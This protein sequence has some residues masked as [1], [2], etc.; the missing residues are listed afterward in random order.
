MITGDYCSHFIAGGVRASGFFRPTSRR[1]DE[2]VAG[3][4]QL[5]RKSTARFRQRIVKHFRAPF[6]FRR[7]RGF[8]RENVNDAPCFRRTNDRSHVALLHIDM[9]K[10]RAPE[11]TFISIT[12]ALLDTV[13]DLVNDLRQNRELR[14]IVCQF[15]TQR[16]QAAVR[17]ADF[18]TIFNRT[19]TIRRGHSFIHRRLVMAEEKGG[20]QLEPPA[21]FAFENAI[22]DVNGV[23][24]MQHQNTFLENEVA[25]MI[26]PDRQP[27]FQAEFMQIIG[28]TEIKLAAGSFFR[29]E[30]DDIVIRETQ[31]FR[32]MA[33]H[34]HAPVRRRKGRN[35]QAVMTP[36]DSAR[37]RARSETAES[38]SHKPLAREEQFS[39]MG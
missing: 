14:A 1:D 16:R 22:D 5:G 7:Y 18:I 37:D 19:Q 15:Y 17:G 12:A 33:P 36:R 28:G 3:K 38:I 32:N 35:K 2:L 20:S 24:Q 26:G 10:S 31:E 11:V 30:G 6:F 39:R 13:N 29:A 8:G 34:H 21:L 23:L 25:H 27:I 9:K 4:N